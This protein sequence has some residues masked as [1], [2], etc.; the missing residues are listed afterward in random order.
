CKR[1]QIALKFGGKVRKD[2]RKVF[3]LS[4]WEI[5]LHIR[6]TMME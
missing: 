2:V 5:G 1:C 4:D 6:G 3:L